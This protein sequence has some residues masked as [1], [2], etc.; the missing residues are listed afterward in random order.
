MSIFQHESD[1]IGMVCDVQGNE[2]IIDY[3]YYDD[4]VLLA[5]I[6]F[7]D[8]TSSQVDLTNATVDYKNKFIVV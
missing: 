2:G 8:H 4:G 1:Y 5:E 7:T 6:T 3:A